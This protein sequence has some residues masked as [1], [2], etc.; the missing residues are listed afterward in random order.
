MLLSAS[1]FQYNCRDRHEQGDLLEHL[2]LQGFTALK[3]LIMAVVLTS[4][5]D[6]HTNPLWPAMGYP[7]S[8]PFWTYLHCS[9]I[10]LSSA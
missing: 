9:R 4:L 8:T 10:G 7:G 3:G 2:M 5:D 1:L 6:T